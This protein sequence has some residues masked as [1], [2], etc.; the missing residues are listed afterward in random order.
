MSKQGS[1]SQADLSAFHGS[2][3][4]NIS[5]ILDVF[6][7][8]IPSDP[9][10]WKC[11]ETGVQENLWL[12]LGTGFIGSGRQNWDGSGGNGAAI[13]HYEATGKK[14]QAL[15]ISFVIAAR[16]AFIMPKTSCSGH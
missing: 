5:C 4:V 3:D 8:V 10:E 7:Q 9:S 1:P 12:N 2:D 11:D 15:P 16:Q 14:V 13:R 6:I